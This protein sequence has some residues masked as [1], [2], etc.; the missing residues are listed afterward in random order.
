MIIDADS[1]WLRGVRKVPS[2]NCDRRP[3]GAALD[4]IVVHGIS[5]PPRQFGGPFIDAL[6]TGNLDP[7]DHPYFASIASARVSAHAMISRSGLLTQ[8]VAFR[9]R[10][11]HAGESSYCGRRG[12]NDFSIG[13]ELEG[14]DDLPYERV[15]YARLAALV[16][17]LRKAYPA[18]ERADIVGHSDI[19]PG[20]KTDPGAAFDWDLLRRLTRPA[21]KAAASESPAL[22]GDA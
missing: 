3:P 12:C 14:A 4:L 21:G 6:F 8:Y 11:W 17:A 22:Y 2:P 20:R 1:G 19:A 9:E 16:K 10:A 18:L 13:V 5:L 15:Q 7:A